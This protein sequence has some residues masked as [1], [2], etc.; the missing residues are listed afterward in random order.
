M[1]ALPV[2]A[3]IGILWLMHRLLRR[4]KDERGLGVRLLGVS[5]APS[6][7]ARP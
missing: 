2:L 1:R 4:T 3:W 7:C 5:L 6:S